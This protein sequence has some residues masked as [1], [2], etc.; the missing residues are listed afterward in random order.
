MIPTCWKIAQKPRPPPGC[1]L[2]ASRPHLHRQGGLILSP[3]P[4]IVSMANW[5]ASIK[6]EPPKTKAELR[7]MLAQAVRNTQPGRAPEPKS[8]RLSKAETVVAPKSTRS[9]GR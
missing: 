5:Q 2:P 8:K 3:K 1:T 9:A 4:H 6:R 7:E